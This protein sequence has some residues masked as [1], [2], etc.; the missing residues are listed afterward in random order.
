MTRN[1]HILFGL[2]GKLIPVECALVGTGCLYCVIAAPEPLA[3]LYKRSYFRGTWILTALDAGFF[4]AMGIKPTW[5]R[6]ILSIIFSA[7]YLVFADAAEEK[8]RKVRATITVEHM[9]TSWE[10]AAS[11][12]ILSF[13]SSLMRPRMTI[14]K[15]IHVPRPASS[16]RA[17]LPPV[18][19][20]LFYAGDL[21][22]LP[23]QTSLI[24]HFPGGGFVSM[25]PPCHEDAISQW[26]VQTGF[27]ICSVNYGK[28]PEYPY[29]WAIEE[30]YD[31]YLSIVQSKGQVL[32]L[33]GDN[34]VKIALIGDSAYVSFHAERDFSMRLYLTY[35]N[36]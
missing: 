4:T 19:L 15:I 2:D 31:V 13:I 23:G 12:P 35:T 36:I 6:H 5:L 14:K 24:L 1:A 34:D 30:C 18:Q 33:S 28:S 7:Y 21:A 20:H 16:E 29:P 32:G 22:S 8:T 27:L 26:A 10:K 9:R 17:T 11:N 25:P 3:R